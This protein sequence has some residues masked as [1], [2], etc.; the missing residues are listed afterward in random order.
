MFFTIYKTTNTKNGKYY[1]GKHQTNNINDDY[2]GSGV[3]LVL[4]IKKY[5]KESFIKEILFIFN[6]EEEMN[7]K[8][9]ELITEDLVRSKNTYNR[10]VGGEGGPH[11]R[12]KTHSSEMKK[13]LSEKIK[14]GGSKLTDEGRMKIIESNKKRTISEETKRKLSDKAKIR[15]INKTA[16]WSGDGPSSVS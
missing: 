16:G 3:S 6:T 2:L 8:E 14:K 11:F 1:L 15:W 5:G 7:R 10:G 13:S 4:A 9:K 12:G